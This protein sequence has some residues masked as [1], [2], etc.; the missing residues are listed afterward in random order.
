MSTDAM[1]R[2]TLDA[3]RARMTR[4]LEYLAEHLDEAVAPVALARIAGL[5]ARQTE[6]VFART[7]GETPRACVRRLRLERAAMR[8]RKSRVSIL[9]VAVDAGFQSHEAFTRA[10]RQRFGHSPV[11]YRRLRAANAQ[12]RARMKLWEAIAATALRP[13][14]ESNAASSAGPSTGKSVSS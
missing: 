10:F 5:S 3:H 6:R 4:V 12:P 13:Y 1:R 9:A 14:V 7:M 2:S 8:L 11:D